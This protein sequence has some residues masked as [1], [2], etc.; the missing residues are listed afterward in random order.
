MWD[1]LAALAD[2]LIAR[3]NRNV[4]GRS[5]PD[6]RVTQTSKQQGRAMVSLAMWTSKTGALPASKTSRRRESLS[7]TARHKQTLRLRSPRP[8]SLSQPETLLS[9]QTPMPSPKGESA[10]AVAK[11]R[12]VRAASAPTAHA[13]T[14][15]RLRTTTFPADSQDGVLVRPAASLALRWRDDAGRRFQPLRTARPFTQ[16]ASNPLSRCVL[17]SSRR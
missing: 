15:G 12:I 1:S 5:V 6:T 8:W 11:R 3:M 7:T 4:G 2:N 13:P 17:H 14:A 16:R 9:L 10:T